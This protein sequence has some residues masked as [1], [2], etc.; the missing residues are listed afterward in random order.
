[1]LVLIQT[2]QGRLVPQPVEFEF[3]NNEIGGGDD[4]LI[5]ILLPIAFLLIPL[6]SHETMLNLFFLFDNHHG[7]PFQEVPR[8]SATPLFV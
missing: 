4:V 5:V 7:F 8:C 6:T 1:M 2:A 3:I